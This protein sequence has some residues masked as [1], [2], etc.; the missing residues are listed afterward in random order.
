M[1]PEAVKIDLR[2]PVLVRICALVLTALLRVV[3]LLSIADFGFSILLISY[4]LLNILLL[5]YPPC[6]R[7]LT[8]PHYHCSQ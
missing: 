5:Y 3:G 2:P 7:L 1:K 4:S 8:D 6:G